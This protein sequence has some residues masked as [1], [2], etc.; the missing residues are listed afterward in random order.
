MAGRLPAAPPDQS[1]HLWLT[2]A[3]RTTLAGTITPNASGFG[4]FVFD[5]GRQG[6]AYQSARLILQPNGSIAPTGTP[7]ASFN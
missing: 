6:P 7:L 5:A 4:F 1:Y 2:E 3:G